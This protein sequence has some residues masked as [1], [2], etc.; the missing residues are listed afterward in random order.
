MRKSAYIAGSIL[1]GAA[2]ATLSIESF[3]SDSAS[4]VGFDF[5]AADSNNVTDSRIYFVAN[6]RATCL[7]ETTGH[8]VWTTAAPG[9]GPDEGP[10]AGPI[11][12]DAGLVYM[13]G[14]GFFTAFSLDRKTGHFDWSLDNR[15]PA[16]A[17]DNKTVFLSLQGGLGIVAID[18]TDGKV[19][20]SRRPIKVGGTIKSIVF[21]HGRLYTDS[22]YVW[23][24]SEGV[25]ST[26]LSSK[27]QSLAANE[28]SVFIVDQ[29]LTLTALD[30]ITGS[31]QWKAVNTTTTQTN[32]L[33]SDI[34]VSNKFVALT[35]YDDA[36]N[37]ATHALL[38]VF[39]ATAGKLL[40]KI[41]LVSSSGLDKSM[42]TVDAVRV[43]VLDPSVDSTIAAYNARDGKLLWNYSD[44]S[45]K[46][47]GP[48]AS[49]NGL[50]LIYGFNREKHMDELYAL[51]SS[52]GTLRWTFESKKGSTVV[53]K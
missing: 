5:V 28:E 6:G 18:S 45:I 7:D 14:G 29:H 26:E 40:W 24:A 3:A 30:A 34:S 25:A 49:F 12:T 32:K 35:T 36:A 10:G 21:S 51:D 47:I 4:K 2:L 37:I 19:K 48:T 53:A 46:F 9:L 1:L 27:P 38:S 13:A 42:V 31:T 41:P 20:W 44:S 50:L 33:D 8:V 15:S 16:L 17:A 22:P 11:L 23:K 39:D 52:T 43:Y